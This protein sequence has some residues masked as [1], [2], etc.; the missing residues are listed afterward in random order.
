MWLYLFGRGII[1]VF[2]GVGAVVLG[3]SFQTLEI[4]MW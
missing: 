2:N 1:G 3:V 4:L